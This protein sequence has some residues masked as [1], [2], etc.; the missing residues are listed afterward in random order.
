MADEFLLVESIPKGG[1]IERG[2]WQL[3]RPML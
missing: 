2:R 3:D 1:H